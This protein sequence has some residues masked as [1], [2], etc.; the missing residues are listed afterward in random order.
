MSFLQNLQPHY[1][2]SMYITAML[3]LKEVC[4]YLVINQGVISAQF[5]V[6][7]S[8]QEIILK[9]WRK[10]PSIKAV[11]CF[12]KKKKK[13]SLHSSIYLYSTF[14]HPY[15]KMTGWIQ[16]TEDNI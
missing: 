2:H 13:K 14:N 5:T 8:L 1:V 10:I 4:L 9:P 3:F 15:K 7:N 6:I 16:H 12:K 11:I